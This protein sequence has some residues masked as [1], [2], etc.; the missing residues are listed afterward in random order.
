MRS[1]RAAAD[2]APAAAGLAAHTRS[3]ATPALNNRAGVAQRLPPLDVSQRTEVLDGLMAVG[4][5]ADEALA[6]FTVRRRRA[7]G[8]AL[9]ALAHSC[10]RDLT[11]QHSC[12]RGHS[13]CH[14]RTQRLK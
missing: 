12:C 13:C 1:R 7:A 4:L 2:A 8:D 5:D 9:L 10:C 6:I 14:Q 11:A 3:G